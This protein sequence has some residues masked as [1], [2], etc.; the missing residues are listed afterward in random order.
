[1]SSRSV[2]LALV[3]VRTGNEIVIGGCLARHCRRISY[4]DVDYFKL[5]EKDTK[6]ARAVRE[7]DAKADGDFVYGV[8]T[9]GVY[10]RPSCPSRDAKREN[11]R[12]YELLASA[13]QDGLRPCKRHQPTEPSI[14]R[15]R[16]AVIEQAWRII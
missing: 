7:R 2:D 15:K 14:T 11:V 5:S 1:M 12:F 4:S 6:I 9:T 3:R 8:L 10:C 16:T 13:K